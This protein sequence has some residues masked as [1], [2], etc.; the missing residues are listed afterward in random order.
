VVATEILCTAGPQQIHNHLLRL[1]D[2]LIR[3]LSELGLTYIGSRV[4]DERSGICTFSGKDTE[5]MYKFLTDRQVYLSL[6]N[7]ALRFS[8][9][10]YNTE[11]EMDQITNLCQEYIR[12]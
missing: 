6:R 1:G 4:P 11:Q 10:F 8:P 5:G 12:K 9:H 2:K 7:Q 3:S